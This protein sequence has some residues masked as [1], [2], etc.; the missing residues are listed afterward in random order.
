MI[1]KKTFDQIQKRLEQNPQ[2]INF[3]KKKEREAVTFLFPGLARCADCGHAVTYEFHKKASGKA[4]KYYRC[5][6]KS[7]SHKCTQRK[8]LREEALL[9]Q[10]IETGSQIAIP[11]DVF[12]ALKADSFDL[13]QKEKGEKLTKVKNLKDK[14]TKINE[15]TNSLLDLHLDG[16]LSKED[17]K[18]KKNSLLNQKIS[19]QE[20]IKDLE[21]GGDCLE[22]GA[23]ELELNFLNTCNQAD[24]FIKEKKYPELNLLLQEIGSNRIIKDQKLEILFNKPFDFL[25][26]FKSETNGNSCH[27]ESETIKH[28]HKLK[29]SS[30]PIAEQSRSAVCERRSCEQASRQEGC[31]RPQRGR[32]RLEVC[33]WR[34]LEFRGDQR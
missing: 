13:S 22:T 12:E 32:L 1:S 9:E 16:E 30:E 31:E 18:A 23:L 33:K 17:Y 3:K 20:E 15:K 2:R 7:Q 10:V 25:A 14:I 5:T 34:A 27:D 21:T 8:Y 28:S 24:N 6:H 26:Q 19:F 11:D 4:F 29:D